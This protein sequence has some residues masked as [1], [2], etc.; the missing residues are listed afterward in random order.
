MFLQ[1]IESFITGRHQLPVIAQWGD[2]NILKSD[3][4]FLPLDIVSEL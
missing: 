2:S 1:A 4:N 3:L